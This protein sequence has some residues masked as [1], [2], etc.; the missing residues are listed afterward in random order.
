M[1]SSNVT[2]LE[3]GGMIQIRTGV[4]QGIG[5]EGPPGPTGER[6]ETGPQGS[7]GVPGP[8]GGVEQVS[9]QFT[10]ASQNFATST[11]T[12]NYPTTW[13]NLAFGTVVRDELNAQ[14]ST[15]NFRLP[16]GRDYTV[17]FK[18]RF[19]KQA[20]VNATGYRALQVVYNG[21]VLTE[22]IISAVSL[23]DTVVTLNMGIRSTSV[24]DVLN[25]KVSHNEPVTIGVAGALWINATGAGVQGEQGIQG[26]QGPQGDVGPQGPVGPPGTI[27]D[28]TTT[29]ST[30]GGTNPA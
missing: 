18:A 7:Q 24:T 20:S 6:G 30:I 17:I 19:Y 12:S 3:S 13:S 15:V 1:S 27:I 4:I 8:T 14:T 25:F 23:T 9:S 2:R 21:V 22:E 5:P 26:I 16:S 29:I 10:A 28:N 11:I